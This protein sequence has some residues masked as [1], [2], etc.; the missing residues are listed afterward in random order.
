MQADKKP[1]AYVDRGFTFMLYSYK[2]GRFMNRPYRG[3][4]GIVVPT[5]EI[6][7]Q[8]NIYFRVFCVVRGQLVFFLAFTRI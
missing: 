2:V 8:Q 6:F 4:I 5:G 7:E 1:P 3:F